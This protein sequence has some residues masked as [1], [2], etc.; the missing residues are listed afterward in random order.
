MDNILQNV[1]LTEISFTNLS[2]IQFHF[3][4]NNIKHS[5]LIYK[6]IL[7]LKIDNDGYFD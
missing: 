2:S 7:I 1:D 6:N 4:K 5:K 3:S